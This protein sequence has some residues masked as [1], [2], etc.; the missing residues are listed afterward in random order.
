MVRQERGSVNNYVHQTG[1]LQH[2]VHRRG[3]PYLSP[4][5]DHLIAAYVQIQ[6]E[7]RTDVGSKCHS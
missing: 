3:C 7:P 4:V 1:R 6:S 5:R 2:L